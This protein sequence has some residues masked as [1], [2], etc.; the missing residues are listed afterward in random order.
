[1]GIVVQQEQMFVLLLLREHAV[2]QG[3]HDSEYF[4]SESIFR[5]A[6][7][8]SAVVF[9]VL[10]FRRVVVFGSAALIVAESCAERSEIDQF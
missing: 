7:H 3:S 2:L 4:A 9:A 1:M 10:S 6:E 8:E 5:I